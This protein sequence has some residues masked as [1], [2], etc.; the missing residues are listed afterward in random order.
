V[1]TDPLRIEFPGLK[2]TEEGSR[3]R[4][5]VGN[6]EKT[7]FSGVLPGFGAWVLGLSLVIVLPFFTLIRTS[8]FLLQTYSLSGW[9]ALLGGAL[10]TVLLLFFYLA[11]LSLRLGGKGRVPKTIRR[12]TGILV[13]AYCLYALV[14]LS[15]ANAKTEEIRATYTSLNPV[16]RVAV[17]TLLLVDREAVLTDTRRTLED[18][19]RWGLPVNQASLHLPQ[20]D[21]YVYAVDIRTIGRPEWQNRAAAF[22]FA[23]MGFD[24]LRHVGTADHLHVGLAPRLE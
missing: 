4:S 2:P 8:V 16:I 3:A 6:R 7:G 10:A 17:S 12:S 14:Y 9:M 13:G 20:A 18:Y 5:G 1:G 15:G 19:E 22:Y 11:I 23:L 24:T 21:G